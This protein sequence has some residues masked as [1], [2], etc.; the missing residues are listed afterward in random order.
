MEN[1]QIRFRDS[2]FIRAGLGIIVLSALPFTAVAFAGLIF[3]RNVE[4]GPT[5]LWFL[6]GAAFGFLAIMLGIAGLIV[7]RLSRKAPPH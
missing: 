7:R 3:H 5:F 6:L 2:W 1:K 4:V